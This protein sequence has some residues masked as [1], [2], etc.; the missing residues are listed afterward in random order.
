MPVWLNLRIKV[1][2][3][4]AALAFAL[5]LWNPRPAPRRVGTPTGTG[6]GVMEGL[7]Q[8]PAAVQQ[9]LT[10]AMKETPKPRI[11]PEARLALEERA[12]GPWGRDPF[13]LEA[14]QLKAQAEAGQNFA[15]SLH[16]S[17]VVWDGARLRA[18][19]NDS[20]VKVGDELD[21]VR[22]VAI[23]RDRVTVSKGTR[24]HVLRLGE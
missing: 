3:V 17:G 4:V 2:L 9:L 20:V 8:L 11:S 19:I 13:A 16:L 6:G 22:I 15:A 1:L 14:A 10:T 23:E 18:V 5:F 24:R 7:R 12:R 21:G